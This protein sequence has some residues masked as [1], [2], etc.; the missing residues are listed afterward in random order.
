MSVE[1]HRVLM[2]ACGWKHQAW[3]N[4]FYAE[5][6]PEEWQLGFYSNE[7]PVVYVPAADWLDVSD[8]VVSNL[9]VADLGEWTEEVS[10]SFRFI[11]E[12][13]ADILLDEQHFVAAI[14]K[15]KILGEFCLGLVFQLSQK[16]CRDITL[17]QERLNIVQSFASV[18][19]DSH[20][21]K[22][23]AEFKDMLLEQ[24]ITQ[25]WDGKSHETDSLKYGS[26]AITHI[27]S[28]GLDIDIAGLRKVVEVSLSASSENCISVLCLDGEPPSLE[29]LRN[30]DIILNLL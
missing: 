28:D 2:G 9:V 25:V 14:K 10:D 5:D 13:P 29:M 15:A 20:G 21:I 24:N 22:L 12:I 1:T 19:V 18:C 8:T 6:L 3:L 26:L 16:T 7:F 30:A 27:S 11:L 23:T 4:D 17:F